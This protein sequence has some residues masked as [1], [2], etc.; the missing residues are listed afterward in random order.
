M[1][2]RSTRLLPVFLLLVGLLTACASEATSGGGDGTPTTD[3]SP[4]GSQGSASAAEAGTLVT[5]GLDPDAVIQFAYNLPLT[6]TDPHA[7]GSG[8][9]IAYLQLLYDNLFEADADGLQ[10]QLVSEWQF[11]DNALLLQLRDDA[12]FHDGS[13]IDATAVKANLDRLRTE[14]SS[15]YVAQMAVVNEVEVVDDHTVRVDLEPQA[16][17]SLPY[18][19][20]GMAGMMVNPKFFD[21]PEVLRTSAPEGAGSGPYKVASWTAGEDSVVFER[22]GEHWDPAAGQAAR[23]EVDVLSGDQALN[24]VE[25]G[26]YDIT[27]TNDLVGDVVARAEAAP[28]ELQVNYSQVLSLSGVWLQDNPHPVV[29]EAMRHAV[30]RDA[31]QAL[32]GPPT[33]PANQLFRTGHPLHVDEIDDLHAYDPARARELVETAPDG[34]TTVTV[35]ARPGHPDGTVMELLQAQMADVGIDLVIEQREGSGLYEAWHGGQVDGMLSGISSIHGPT[36]LG[37]FLLRGSIIWAAP[38]SALDAIEA[39]MLRA[40]DP[41]LSD[42]E[43]NQIYRDILL[44]AAEETWGLFLYSQHSASLASADLVNLDVPQDY[45]FTSLR[46]AGK[47]V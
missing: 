34:A 36:T 29:G 7:P 30:D 18:L 41:A 27:G 47:R 13:P 26:Q 15:G 9:S 43:R 1:S 44:R 17:A 31:I 2:R 19:W 40:D 38:D 14:E 11:R 32:F 4:G 6:T 21:V 33:Q 42:E 23:I 28:D 22:A 37:V 35:A 12:T 3:A 24:A 20:A 39:E 8:A 46:Y 5:E 25:T 45:W 16:G 10:A